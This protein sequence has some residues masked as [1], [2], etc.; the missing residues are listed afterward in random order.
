[1]NWGKMV[2]NSNRYAKK[3]YFIQV[4]VPDKVRNI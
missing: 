2:I 4:E 3:I 1:M